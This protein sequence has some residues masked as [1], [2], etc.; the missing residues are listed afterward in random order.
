MLKKLV[1]HRTLFA[2][3][4]AVLFLVPYAMY[5]IFGTGDEKTSY[6]IAAPLVMLL[7]HGFIRFAFFV[8]GKNAPKKYMRF[9]AWFFGIFGSLSLLLY[10][11]DFFLSFPNGFSPTLGGV[12]GMLSALPYAVRKYMEEE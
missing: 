6:V 7:F 1:A 12:L 3:L 11:P 9:A 4:C 5:A 2:I 10:Y 8:V